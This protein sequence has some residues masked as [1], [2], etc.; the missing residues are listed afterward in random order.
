MTFTGIFLFDYFLYHAFCYNNQECKNAIIIWANV[1][2]ET[3]FESRIE[4]AL[5]W[6][7]CFVHDI[8]HTHKCGEN[9]VCLCLWACHG[10]DPMRT[11]TH[12]ITET[13]TLS[14]NKRR[15]K[16]INEY[17]K[18]ASEQ[19]LEETDGYPII[20]ND[21][22]VRSKNTSYAKNTILPS[23]SIHHAEIHI[24]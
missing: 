6:L 23:E 17:T 13:V 12:T 7:A 15:I 24:T 3:R 20:I 21:I 10:P 19:L 11:Q 1:C 16:Q 4:C 22:S 5:R 14:S 18:L 9:K 8:T 2:K